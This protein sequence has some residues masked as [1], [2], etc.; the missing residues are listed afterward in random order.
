LNSSMNEK[1]DN[2]RGGKTVKWIELESSKMSKWS[3]VYVKLKGQVMGIANA[4]HARK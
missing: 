2:E 4:C 3:G 1:G